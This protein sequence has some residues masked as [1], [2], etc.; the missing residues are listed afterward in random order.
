MFR[1]LTDAF[2]ILGTLLPPWALALLGVLIAIIMGPAWFDGV[3]SKQVRGRIRKLLRAESPDRARYADEALALAGERPRRLV[4]LVREAHKYGLR[5]LRDRAL[6]R[7][8]ATGRAVEDVRVLKKLVKK[9]K[10][11]LRDPLQ[12]VVRVE[13]LLDAGL[14]VGA[15][16]ALAEALAQH[17]TDPDL[18]ALRARV[19]AALVQVPTT[20]ADEPLIDASEAPH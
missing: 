3:R 9:D 1:G 8:H 11:K 7:L 5:D 17:P 20:A 10:Q 15:E 14:P 19:E 16:E 4:T 2:Q 12:G 13:H 18:L 6:T